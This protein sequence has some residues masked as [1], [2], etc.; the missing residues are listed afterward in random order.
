ME[1]AYLLHIPLAVIVIGALVY[2]ACLP[3]SLRDKEAEKL[4][5]EFEA[6]NAK[7]DALI[8]DYYKSVFPEDFK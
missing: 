3:I 7:I 5:A 6:E 4:Q 8:D 1:Y 2:A